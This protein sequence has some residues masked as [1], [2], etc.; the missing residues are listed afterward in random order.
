M[1]F[2]KIL[3]SLQRFQN[4]VFKEKIRLPGSKQTSWVLCFVAYI[5]QKPDWNCNSD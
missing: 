5:I 3:K 4:L 1:T 2:S